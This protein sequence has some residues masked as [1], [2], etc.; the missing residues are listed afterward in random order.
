MGKLYSALVILSII[1][2][3]SFLFI[4]I[5]LEDMG[6][7]GVVFGRCI[8]GFLTLAIFTLIKREKIFSKDLPLSKLIL[9]GF[10]NNALPWILISAGQTKISSSL[11]SI[12]NATTPIMTLIIGSIFFSTALRKNQWI[13]IGLG[14]IGILIISDLNSGDLSG[15]LSGILCLLGATICYGT[16]TQLTKKYL[17]Q[18]TTLHISLFT[19]LSA[20]I[21]SFIIMLITTPES[22]AAFTKWHVIF[23]L[24]GLGSLGSGIAYLLYYYLIKEGSPEFASL[25][26]YIVPGS[27]IMWGAFIL[28]E[29]IHFTM[30]IGLIVIF[31]GVY[32]TSMKVKQKEKKAAA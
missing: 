30:I 5:L 4:K 27:A 29:S 11:A 32:I 20:A 17:G 6:P 21:I 3:T 1:W 16:G 2:G 15:H 10:L 25:V 18:V 8:F 24:L 9:V 12:I 28:G 14:F 23:S 26:T 22:L 13:G 7:A 19:M 31:I